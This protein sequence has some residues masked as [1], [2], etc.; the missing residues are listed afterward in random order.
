MQQLTDNN[1]A[2]N[3]ID[4]RTME[5]ELFPCTALERLIE[6]NGYA[7]ILRSNGGLYG[8]AV[9]ENERVIGTL[10]IN[11]SLWKQAKVRLCGMPLIWG[12]APQYGVPFR[13]AVDLAMK[14]G[15]MTSCF[16]KPE[17]QK[18]LRCCKL[19][20]K[21]TKV[22]DKRGSMMQLEAWQFSPDSNCAY[23]LHAL[24]Q[25]FSSQ[26]CHFDGATIQF[27]D[28]GLEA[29]LAGSSKIKGDSK[30]KHFRIDGQITIE[31]MHQ[32]ASAFLPAMELYDEAFE[33]TAE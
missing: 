30:T 5:D 8:F 23:Y 17:T 12:A 11:D 15:G 21:V 14:S 26:V 29:M 33:V 32:L 13:N 28:S 27:S 18:G 20:I 22:D 9:P 16:F 1:K 7:L 6:S 10:V 4:L 3:E 31:D 2:F 24:S 19:K 25:D